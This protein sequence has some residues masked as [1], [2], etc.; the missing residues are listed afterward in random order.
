MRRSVIAEALTLQLL[1]VHYSHLD[2]SAQ[3]ASI[4]PCTSDVHEPYV[5]NLAQVRSLH[6]HLA[7]QPPPCK[8][9]SGVLPVSCHDIVFQ[10][11]VICV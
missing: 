6:P 11:M 8:I 5:Q 9:H 3:A 7:L 10:R 2:I 4:G 1:A